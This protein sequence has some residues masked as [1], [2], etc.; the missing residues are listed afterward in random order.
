MKSIWILLLLPLLASSQQLVVKHTGQ[1]A[2]IIPGF[3]QVPPTEIDVDGDGVL[4]A[5]VG[6]ITEGSGFHG[7]LNVIT[8]ELYRLSPVASGM[9]LQWMPPRVGFSKCRDAIHAEY[10]FAE[11]ENLVIMD[12]ASGE[13]LF[14]RYTD[15]G[16]AKVLVRDYDGDGLDDIFVFSPFRTAFREPA[17]YNY[18]V[19]GTGSASLASPG[20]TLVITDNGYDKQL[21]WQSVPGADGYRVLW[22]AD[23]DSPCFTQ[24]GYTAENTF[25]H[26]GFADVPKG[27]YKVIAVSVGGHSGRLA[28]EGRQ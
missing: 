7:F 24:V 1:M 10:V 8:G 13:V 6:Y 17:C 2:D 25:T 22:G 18:I 19:L 5:N 9:D 16:H 4:E 28:G 14:Q 11:N 20:N 12:M 26:I 3:G 15:G 23:P 21:A 27:F